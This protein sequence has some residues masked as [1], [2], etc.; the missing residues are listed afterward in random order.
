MLS[1]P[2]ARCLVACALVLGAF[3]PADP[4]AAAVDGYT[5]PIVIAPDGVAFDGRIDIRVRLYNQV[6]GGEQLV[7][8]KVVRGLTCV[9]GLVTPKLNFAN[10]AF[11]G[12]ARFL[13]VEYR[14]SGETRFRSAGP[15][16]P[17]LTAAYAQFAVN[18]GVAGVAG[19]QGPQGDVGPQGPQGP[20]G[21][22]GPAGPTG[23]T[24]ATG[25]TGSTGATGPAGQQGDQGPPAAPANPLQLATGR[26]YPPNINFN[27]ASLSVGDNPCYPC[28]D[29]EYLWVPCASSASLY[30]IRARTS[31]IVTSITVPGLPIG[32]CFDG[33]YVWLA[34]YNTVTRV[35]PVDNSITSVSI[36]TDNKMVAFDG[37]YIWVTAAGDNAV[38]VINPGT[39]MQVGSLNSA[40]MMPWGL[41]VHRG[42]VFA[43]GF[44]NGVVHRLSYD[45]SQMIVG[46]SRT[47]S[48]A[49]M[50]ASDGRYLWVSDYLNQNVYR[51]DPDDNAATPVTIPVS[52]NP[53][54]LIFDGRYVVFAASYTA[55]RLGFIDT[56]NNT[57][58]AS[59]ATGT[60]GDTGVCFDGRNY[61][62][63]SWG[64]DAVSRR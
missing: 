23:A 51:V 45:G 4:A 38:Y 62:V 8:A 20:Q 32:S 30:K 59:Q 10:T 64:E 27:D 41:A 43:A 7:P 55:D 63:T 15:R 35:N 24:G 28:F 52:T 39:M 33:R 19:P 21:D 46:Q 37:R 61:W 12:E 2:I 50:L 47:L 26:T 14:P 9:G 29:G 53:N 44:G 49:M 6:T 57:L 3:V 54:Q 13:S 17:V 42:E 5:Q 34:T 40:G 58:V 16:I 56:V 25:A 22:Q 36:G 48:G 31:E 1:R 18:A 60:S 11:D